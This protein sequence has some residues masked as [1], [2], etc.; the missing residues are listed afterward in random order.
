VRGSSISRAPSPHRAPAPL[1][2]AASSM[3]ATLAMLAGLAAC[4]AVSPMP[5]ASGGLLA[6]PAAA[7]LGPALPA[8]RTSSDA[9][10][11][12]GELQGL[13]PVDI[14]RQFGQPDFRRAEPP[15]ELWQYRTAGCV[16]DIFLYAEPDGF[17][18]L[19]AEARGRAGA[20][21]SRGGCFEEAAPLPAGQRQSHL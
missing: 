4:S 15:A 3:L 18:V 1:A 5:A 12:L 17:H 13:R 2:L 9:A 14:V 6:T 16:L 19:H 20:V 8:P 11:R 7:V 10:S 21:A